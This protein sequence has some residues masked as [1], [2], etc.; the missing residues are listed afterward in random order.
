[1]VNGWRTQTVCANAFTQTKSKR[2]IVQINNKRMAFLRAFGMVHSRFYLPI[3]SINFHLLINGFWMSGMSG[4]VSD[5]D[6]IS[7]PLLPF[8]D[9]APQSLNGSQWISFR[10]FILLHIV[11]LC[12][13]M[14]I[15]ITFVRLWCICV[16]AWICFADTIL[17]LLRVCF[18]CLLVAR[19]IGCHGF[20]IIDIIS[21][22][23]IIFCLQFRLPN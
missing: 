10:M 13:A 19:Y 2:F 23:S 11:Y 4:W 21:A 7:A 17:K 15:Q 8:Y 14:R 3:D 16:F 5:R 9:I 20:G 12:G 22:N 18:V 1:M 6:W